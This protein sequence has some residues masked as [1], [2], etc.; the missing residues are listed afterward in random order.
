[1]TMKA[2][3]NILRLPKLR[4]PIGYGD[5]YRNGTVKQIWFIGELT[6]IWVQYLHLTKA[7]ISTV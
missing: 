5:K 4:Y 7:Y 3:N 6:V 2:L 1:M